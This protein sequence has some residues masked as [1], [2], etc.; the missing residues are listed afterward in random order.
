MGPSSRPSSSYG[1]RKRRASLPPSLGAPLKRQRR[2]FNPDYLALLNQDITD[3]A[4]GMVADDITLAL[5]ELS[6]VGAVRWSRVEKESLYAA[7]GRLGRDDLPGIAARVGTK[8]P[9]E[10]R[11]LL[12]LLAA[13]ARAH[14]DEGDLWRK[15]LRPVDVPAAA[16][17]TQDCCA[18]LDEAADDLALRQEAHEM[19]VEKKRWGQAEWCI[20]QASPFLDAD[21]ADT[22]EPEVEQPPPPFAQLFV[23]RNWLRLSQRIFMNST[24]PEYNWRYVSEEPPAIRATALSDLH[25]LATSI[26]KRLVMTTLFMSESRIKAR[27]QHLRGIR[28]LVKA[29]DVQAAVESLGLKGDSHELWARAA[30]RLRLD[31]YRDDGPTEDDP[32]QSGKETSD[33][34]MGEGREEEEE[35]EEVA[36]SEGSLGGSDNE[37][38]EDILSYEEVEALLLG[39]K[40]RVAETEP[41]PEP[42][43]EDMEA[44][45]EDPDQDTADS[46]KP[47]A[48]IESGEEPAVP[49]EADTG[50]D[51]GMDAGTGPG[52]EG[53]DD[54][55]AAADP[56]VDDEVVEADVREAMHFAADWGGTTRSRQ[57]LV[58]RIRAEHVMEA[59]AAAA[60]T[61]TS[62]REEA[63]LWAV[64]KRP[65]P[66]GPSAMKREGGEQPPSARPP[67]RAIVEV[68]GKDW[69]EDCLSAE[70]CS[71]VTLLVPSSATQ[72]PKTT[73]DTI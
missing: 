4:T 67:K 64:L 18:A 25:T 6:Q 5:P 52:A 36:A 30:R 21:E 47:G 29:K 17:L 57:A 46:A 2:T 28:Q 50:G 60:D 39:N 27:R 58:G 11:Q 26:T 59:E 33:K 44:S 24:I 13:R 69:R 45:E 7:L 34:E 56:R 15:I 41:P 40:A 53:D 10:V 9:L 65:Q 20:T 22:A 68:A 37:G 8:S 73:N 23:L 55:D 51:G 38:E 66:D 71:R 31:V 35:E 19:A 49:D 12:V 43:D 72:A 61:Q 48:G 16:E 42:M 14:M 1:H 3:A 32:D 70:V 54:D 62:C 63:Q